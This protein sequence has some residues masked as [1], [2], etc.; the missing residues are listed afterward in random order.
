MCIVPHKWPDVRRMELKLW[1]YDIY[2]GFTLSKLRKQSINQRISINI[3]SRIAVLKWRIRARKITGIKTT[4]K[5]VNRSVE[6]TIAIHIPSIYTQPFLK[7][8]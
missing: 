8:T 6:I 5:L 3:L 1:I 4:G 7:L 2:P